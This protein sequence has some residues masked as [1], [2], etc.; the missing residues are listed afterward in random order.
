MYRSCSRVVSSTDYEITDSIAL[1]NTSGLESR[2]GHDI[3]YS[4]IF[5]IDF[6]SNSALYYIG[7]FRFHV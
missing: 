4:V 5:V 1:T 6:K 3:L 2:M 7:P